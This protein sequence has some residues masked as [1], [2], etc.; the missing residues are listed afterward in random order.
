MGDVWKQ[1]YKE[2]YE[3]IKCGNSA[4]SILYM[5]HSFIDQTLGYKNNYISESVKKDIL[6][7]VKEQGEY[8]IEDIFFNAFKNVMPKKLKNDLEKWLMEKDPSFPKD[9]SFQSKLFIN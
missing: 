2:L 6:A 5:I 7:I 8:P 3:I 9:L 1:R 4:G